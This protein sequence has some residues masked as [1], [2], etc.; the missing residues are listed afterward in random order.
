VGPSKIRSAKRSNLDAEDLAAIRALCREPA[1]A[2]GVW[3]ETA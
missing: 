2:L 3:E 1:E